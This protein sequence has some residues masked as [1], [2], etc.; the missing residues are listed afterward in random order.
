MAIRHVGLTLP[1]WEAE[2]AKRTEFLAGLPGGTVAAVFDS[3]A[4]AVGT[5]VQ[6][7]TADPDAD[8]WVRNGEEAAAAIRGARSGRSLAVRLLRGF[9]DE[10]LM[11]REVLRQA[12]DG[13]S[14]LVVRTSDRGC[15]GHF[16]GAAHVY[17]FGL[18]TFSSLR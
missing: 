12:D 3:R 7:L 10:E 16:S 6:I 9:G 8:V 4:D 2:K 18:W 15:L 17:R 13:R 1:S 5:A 11:V 14:V